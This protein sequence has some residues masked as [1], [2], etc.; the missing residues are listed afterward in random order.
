VKLRRP[1]TGASV[2]ERTV[3]GDGVQPP[4]RGEDHAMTQG[5][6]I[7]GGL[8]IEDAGPIQ[9]IIALHNPDSLS[10]TL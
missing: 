6:R 8:A 3:P 10:R 5:I 4:P 7:S 9:R 1:F 2:D